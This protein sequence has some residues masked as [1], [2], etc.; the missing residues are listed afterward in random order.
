MAAYHFVSRWRI[1]APIERV[2]E[3]IF[4]A[5]RWP[6]WWKY[7]DRVDELEPGAADGVGRRQHLLF[8]TRLPYKVA[9]DVRAT[10]VRPPSALEAEATGELEGTGRWTLVPDDGGTLVRYDWDVRTTRWWM[11]LLAPIAR[12][13]FRWNHDQLMREGGESLARR[14][15][16][17]LELPDEPTRRHR[18][19]GSVG[20]A[21]LAAVVVAL[22]MLARRRRPSRRHI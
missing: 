11:N 19:A 12:P 7:V 4:H 13:A 3:E 6:S 18:P 17:A 10:R 15:G 14:L 5:E 20:W 9:F 2:W 16:A 8:K 1:Q 21:A 22:L